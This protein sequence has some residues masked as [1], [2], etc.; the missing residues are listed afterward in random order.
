MAINPA[1]ALQIRLA[2]RLKTITKDHS[3]S[4][5]YVREA[6]WQTINSGVL[7]YATEVLD[8]VVI[9]FSVEVRH[10]F[11]DK[12]L[13][14]LSLALPFGQKFQQGWTRSIVRHSMA[15][16]LPQQVQWRESK[17]NLSA[18]FQSGLLEKERKLLNQVVFENPAIIEKYVDVPVLQRVYRRY[19][20]QPLQQGRDAMTVNSVVVLALWLQN[21]AFLVP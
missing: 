3:K 20:T 16:L 8:K 18:N 14:E 9:P 15:D 5:Y 21:S 10:P 19:M 2:E 17:G 12:R 6:H 11:F 7:Q 13:V 4:E 1:F